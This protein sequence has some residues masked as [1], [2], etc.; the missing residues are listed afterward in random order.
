MKGDRTLTDSQYAIAMRLSALREH[1][2]KGRGRG[3]PLGQAPELTATGNNLG[4]IG[5]TTIA[6][7]VP[8]AWDPWVHRN[9]E[10]V[11]ET[12][13]HLDVPP[14]EVRACPWGG[15]LIVHPD[16]EEGH[17]DAPFVLVWVKG[18]PPY[19]GPEVRIA[20][21]GYLKDIRRKVFWR[22]IDVRRPA[23][24]IPRY[25]EGE[26]ILAPWGAKQAELFVT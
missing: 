8:D 26:R 15:S 21:W 7:E 10:L 23:Y 11:A 18:E 25:H 3:N 6:R 14:W 12:V 4:M 2:A 19:Y 16:E 22:T 9:D 13:G 20:G 1:T 5:E 17:P 24:F